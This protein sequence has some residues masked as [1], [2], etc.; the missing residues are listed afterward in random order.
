MDPLNTIKITTALISVLIAFTAGFI[1]LRLNPD[2]WLNRWFA[3]FFISTSL[4]FL[5]Y[6]I[7]HLILNFSQ[8]IIPIMIIAQIIFNLVPV[9]AVMTVFVLE[10]FKKVA[11]DLRHLGIMM[12]LFI[13]M[14]IGFFIW[15]PELDMGNYEQGIVNTE[16]PLGWFLFVNTMRLILSIFVVYRYA[17]IIRKLEGETKKRVVWF[18]IGI[19][20]A[21]TGMFINVL[22]GFLDFIFLEILA[23]IL[24]DI[25]FVV[26]IKGFF[27]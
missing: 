3:I 6:T 9:S 21:I 25:G 17:M 10:K 16:T 27:I 5:T 1:E 23:L 2:Y 7:Y 22:G 26:V 4:G 14:S 20:I 13:I 8:I 19:I 11:M 18:F 12:G 24:I 15:I